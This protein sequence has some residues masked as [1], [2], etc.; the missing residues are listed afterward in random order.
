MTTTTRLKVQKSKAVAD[1][2][3]APSGPTTLTFYKGTP[4]HRPLNLAKNLLLVAVFSAGD[5]FCNKSDGNRE[6]FDEHVSEA[7]YE[8]SLVGKRKFPSFRHSFLRIE[9]LKHSC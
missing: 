3:K 2:P 7:I 6:K 5:W 9:A 8:A 1:Q 4:L